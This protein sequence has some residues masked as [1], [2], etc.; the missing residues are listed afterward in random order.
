MG[1]LVDGQWTTRSVQPDAKGRFVR[2]RTRFRQFIRRDGSTPFAPAE[3]RYHLYVSWA[4]PWA[5]RVLIARA[6]LGLEQAIS[7]S[8]VDHFMGDRGWRFDPSV[9]GAT[10][11]PIHGARHLSEVYVAA[12]PSF[13]G[14]VTVPVLWDR[15]SGTIV[16]NE[17]REI[18]RM[19]DHECTS[20]ARAPVDLAP[21]AL[22]PAVESA[23]DAIYEPINNGVYK[24]GFAGSQAAHDEAIRELFA[25]L[26]HWNAVLGE[27]RWMTG[28][29][30]TEADLFLF[31]TLI[32]FD[33]VYHTHFKCNRRRVVDYPNLW[34]FVRELYQLPAVA[35][36]CNFE[37][38]RRH[39]FGS[40]R[41]INPRG[42]VAHG[43]Q[44]ELDGPHG[45]DAVGGQ[46]AADLFARAP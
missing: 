37:H 12:E 18:V 5:H 20:L 41:S 46:A 14:R 43:P 39:Y 8:V 17:S 27:Q 22:R 33:L 9:A 15:T 11:D 16:N 13:T 32:R 26:D 34:G 25:A 23:I 4:C 31:T 35:T 36:T 19:L 28:E 40:H 3:G 45:R 44:L 42:I 30:L 29:R 24:A 2:S 1:M 6:L 38:I 7:V 21:G 10:D